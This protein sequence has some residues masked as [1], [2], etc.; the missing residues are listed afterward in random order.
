MYKKTK[1]SLRATSRLWFPL[2][3]GRHTTKSINVIFL[4]IARRVFQLSLFQ[5]IYFKNIF[6]PNKWS[7]RTTVTVIIGSTAG[8]A[9]DI[10]QSPCL[11]WNMFLY[12]YLNTPTHIARSIWTGLGQHTMGYNIQDYLFHSG[13]AMRLKIHKAALGVRL[14]SV[15]LSHQ[16]VAPQSSS[17]SAP[18]LC[19]PL[20]ITPD[21]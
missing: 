1:I 3:Y 4:S 8:A 17:Y 21:S 13:K 19:E 14:S 20:S 15:R 12:I 7:W 16:A 6:C 2:S 5:G 10:E 18:S 9:Y 11:A